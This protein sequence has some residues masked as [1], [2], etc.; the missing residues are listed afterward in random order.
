MEE[1]TLMFEVADECHLWSEVVKSLID[2][3]FTPDTAILY[4]DQVVAAFKVR[5]VD[6]YSTAKAMYANAQK[7]QVT[8]EDGVILPF[9]EPN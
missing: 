6:L 4:A 7:G 9:K 5:G 8:S 3:S 2:Q 1:E